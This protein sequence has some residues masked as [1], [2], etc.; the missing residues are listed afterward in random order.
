MRNALGRCGDVC[1][2]VVIP[3][4]TTHHL[5]IQRVGTYHLEI[6]ELYSRKDKFKRCT[7]LSRV[8]SLSIFPLLSQI[9]ILP[10]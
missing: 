4:I 7:S 8:V 9:S 2:G 1:L 6:L 3:S 10:L 5:E